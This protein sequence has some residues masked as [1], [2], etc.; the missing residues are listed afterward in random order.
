MRE[1]EERLRKLKS[2]VSNSTNQW[3]LYKKF[4]IRLNQYSYK[5]SVNFP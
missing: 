3:D 4:L 2:E 1:L 5:F